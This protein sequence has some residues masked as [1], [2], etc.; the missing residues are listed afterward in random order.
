MSIITAIKKQKKNPERYN[1]FLDGKFTAAIN[2]NTLITKKLRIEQEITAEQLAELLLAEK[3]DKLLNLAYNFLDYRPRAKKELHQYLNGKIYQKKISFPSEKQKNAVV[4]QV[5]D[6]LEK[7]KYLDDRHFG[8]WWIEQRQNSAKPKGIWAI[9]SELKQKGLSS[10]LIVELLNSLDSDQ[11]N[12]AYA[13]VAKQY[14]KKITRYEKNTLRSKAT[15]YL[16]RRG[17]SYS[18]AKSAVDRLIKEG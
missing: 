10:T 13:A 14:Q 12:L 17:F 4:K 1:I 16:T 11:E 6:H 18:A 9:K 8:Q 2:E 5:M 15:Q 7:K 3:K